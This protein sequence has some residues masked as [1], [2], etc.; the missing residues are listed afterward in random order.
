MEKGFPKGES[1]LK[2]ANIYTAV[3][4]QDSW[5]AGSR[6]EGILYV[7]ICTYMRL[8]MYIYMCTHIFVTSKRIRREFETKGKC[9]HFRHFTGWDS[10]P[11]LVNYPNQAVDKYHLKLENVMNESIPVIQWHY[12]R[13]QDDNSTPV[14]NS[15]IYIYTPSAQ[16][17]SVE[18][19]S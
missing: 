14:L 12:F 8:Y 18:D 5:A 7:Y 17:H 11:S 10:L 3:A 15:I 16:A 6:V 13:L 2:I 1:L 9:Y 19:C 4:V